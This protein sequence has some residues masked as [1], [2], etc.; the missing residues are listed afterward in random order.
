MIFLLSRSL[1]L[2]PSGAAEPPV[3]EIKVLFYAPLQKSIFAANLK[4]LH[5]PISLK[6]IRQTGAVHSLQGRVCFSEE[7]PHKEVRVKWAR[8]NG[9]LRMNTVE[10][11]T[12]IPRPPTTKSQR[13]GDMNKAPEYY[14][15]FTGFNLDEQVLRDWLKTCCKPA[16]IKEKL[17]TRKDLSKDELTNIS[18]AHKFDPLPPGWF[19]NGLQFVS[20]N[21]EKDY[22]HPLLETFIESYLMQINEEIKRRNLMVDH[23]P[24]VDIFTRP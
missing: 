14:I 1:G 15:I 3:N 16:P 19:Y 7:G 13:N 18:S 22:S 9:V 21:G 8:L 24:K 10:N 23:T 4:A 11:A 2:F 5:G 12:A 6:E 20:L 17:K